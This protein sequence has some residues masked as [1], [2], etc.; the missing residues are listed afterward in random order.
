MLPEEIE[1]LESEV[2]YQ[3]RWLKIRKDKICFRDG[4]LSAFS[5]LEKPNFVLIAAMDEVRRICLV[6]QYRYPIR[7]RIWELPGGAWEDGAVEPLDAARGELR[8]ETGLTAA[9][10]V[11]VGQL[12]MAS[13]LTPQSFDVFFATEL[14]QGDCALEPNEQGLIARAF[15]LDAIERMIRRGEI[16]DAATISALHLLRLHGL[17]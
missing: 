9:N 10:I 3:T 14:T 12:L 5:V 1:T 13:G 8:E 11:S 17:V 4:T 16:R 6:E 2:V 7:R 15:S